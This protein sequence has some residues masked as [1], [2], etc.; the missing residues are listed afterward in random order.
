MVRGLSA[1]RDWI[2]TSSTGAR[3]VGCRAPTAAKIE[4]LDDVTR[5]LAT[6]TIARTARGSR[7]RHPIAEMTSKNYAVQTPRDQQCKPLA[8]KR[9]Q[10]CASPPIVNRHFAQVIAG[11][12]GL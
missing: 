8:I 6:S 9:K 3:E 10:E 7:H 1:G 4:R 5:W 12:A 11:S 2:R